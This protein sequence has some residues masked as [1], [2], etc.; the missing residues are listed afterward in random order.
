MP[1]ADS[2]TADTWQTGALIGEIESLGVL[3]AC[4]GRDPA[5]P[6]ARVPADVKL[7][8]PFRRPVAAISDWSAHAAYHAELQR[9]GDPW[10][11]AVPPGD[12]PA[13]E[14]ADRS[15][16]ARAEHADPRRTGADRGLRFGAERLPVLHGLSLGLRR[17]PTAGRHGAG[18]A[19]PGRPGR[20]AGAGQAESAAAHRGRGA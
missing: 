11:A 9:A 18:A 19:G 8:V 12:R 14:R 3:P 7:P 1:A 6:A 17:R 2:W 4:R 16:A 13:A 10:P 5:L 20:R 15:A